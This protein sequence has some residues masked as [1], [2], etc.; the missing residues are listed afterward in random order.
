MSHQSPSEHDIE[1]LSAYLD[2]ELSHR[3]RTALEQQLAQDP[4]LRS[5]LQGLRETVTLVHTL[6]RLKAPR[7]FTLDASHHALPWWQRWLSLSTILQLSGAVGAAASVALIILA[8]VLTGGTEQ[9][10]NA[11]SI[12]PAETSVGYASDALIITPS[13]TPESMKTPTP[14]PSATGTPAPTNMPLPIPLPTTTLAMENSAAMAMPPGADSAEGE[15]S[16]AAPLTLQSQA[17]AVEES[18]SEIAQDQAYSNQ[19]GPSGAEPTNGDGMRDTNDETAI[20]GTGSGPLPTA[21]T[22]QAFAAAAPE[23]PPVIVTTVEQELY[24]ATE[25]PQE[26]QVSASSQDDENTSIWLIGSGIGLLVI[27]LVVFIWGRFKA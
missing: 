25:E 14:A 6:P 27:S 26:K 22:V 18:P 11:Q 1:L 17:E 2:G 23:Q 10:E 12:A 5:T 3:E 8:L 7:N 16:A 15:T 20:G 13:K 9:K 24:I 19:T 4:V 21:G